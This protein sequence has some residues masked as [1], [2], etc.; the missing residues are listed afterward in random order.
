MTT[1]QA[2]SDLTAAGPLDGSELVEATQS[3]GSVQTTTQDIADLA[4]EPDTSGVA[5]NSQAANYTLVLGDAGK[6]IRVTA[7]ATVTVPPESSVD[8][9]TVGGGSP[10]VNVR[11]A[12]AAAVDIAAGTGVT[13]NTP[14][15]LVLDGQWA[16]VSLHYVGSDEWDLVGAVEASS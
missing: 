15:T 3:G 11:A 6:V 13:I 10:V 8:W 2:I 16:E 14:E 9:S 12:T 5:I 4:P 1:P 7:E